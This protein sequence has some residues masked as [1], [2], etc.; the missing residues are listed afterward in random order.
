MRDFAFA[1]ATDLTQ[2]VTA[3]ADGAVA[4]AGG[5]ELLNWMR[6]GIADADS[7][8]DIGR[9]AELR[10]IAVQGDVLRIGALATLNEIGESEL[11][12]TAAPVLAQACLKAAS[13]QLRNLATIG[14]NVLQKTRCPYFRVEA[15]DAGAMPWA[16]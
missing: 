4:I 15:A 9:L 3:L 14:G 13:A 11:V 2:A 16:T 5:T 7:V 10:G 12:R 6:L 8:I 1:R